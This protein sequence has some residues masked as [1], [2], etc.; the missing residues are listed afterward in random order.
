MLIFKVQ[1]F[2][3]VAVPVAEKVFGLDRSWHFLVDVKLSLANENDRCFR[4]FT[5]ALRKILPVRSERIPI[6][7][8]INLIALWQFYD[9]Q[10]SFIKEKCGALLVELVADCFEDIAGKR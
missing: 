7:C 6:L 8:G 10:P 9:A 5:F 3:T 1:P 2:A 4:Q